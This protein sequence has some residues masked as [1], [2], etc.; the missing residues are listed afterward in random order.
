MPHG[1]FHWC[2]LSAYNVERAKN[3]YGE[4][5]GWRFTETAQPDGAP[6]HIAWTDDGESAGLFAM[7]VK[8]RDMGMP[9]FWMS[10]IQA[11]DI[12]RVVERARELGGKVEF[13]PQDFG[14]GAAIALIRDPLGAGFTVYQ[15]EDLS[16]R[17]DN[18]HP[19]HLAWNVLHVSDASAVAG[20][21]ERLFDWQ[22]LPDPSAE[23]SYSIRNAIGAPISAIYVQSDVERGGYQ[24]W[25]VFFA[26]RD[27]DEAKARLS[28]LGGTVLSEETTATGRVLAAQDGDGAAFFLIAAH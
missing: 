15:G 6:Y 23:N 26:V 1:D 18:A 10:Y 25:G 21:Y 17:Q 14:A 2:D 9:S 22:I 20:F 24:Y 7:P 27:L 12:D 28:E 8:F 11:D 3:F 4:L 16:P 5:L 19:G 13:G